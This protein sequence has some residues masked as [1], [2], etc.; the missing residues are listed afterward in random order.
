MQGRK[1]DGDAALRPAVEAPVSNEITAFIASCAAARRQSRAL[2]YG[3]YRNVLLTN[4][5]I[6]F[7]RCVEGERVLVAINADGEPFTAHFDA[8]AG[9]AR[10]LLSGGMHDFGGGSLLPPYSVAYWRVE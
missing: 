5:Q 4:R 8:Q 1:S 10:E 2:Q 3:S 6:I 9:R 7:E